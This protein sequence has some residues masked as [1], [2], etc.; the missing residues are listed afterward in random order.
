MNTFTKLRNDANKANY[1]G[2]PSISAM[3][4]AEIE[5]MDKAR[6]FYP[7]IPAVVDYKEST[8]ELTVE[9]VEGEHIEDYA[10]RTKDFS[11]L[12]KLKDIFALFRKQEVEL[13]HRYTDH[14]K[15][16]FICYHDYDS[17]NFIV[18]SKGNI[19]LVDWDTAG[20]Y[21]TSRLPDDNQEVKD[22]Y[23]VV[24]DCLMK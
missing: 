16:G 23:R 5:I 24:F 3:T 10:L 13:T 21:P 2:F 1:F 8:R 20:L 4:R 19:W 17:T 12:Q 14:Y 11:I 22:L 18:D 15:K 7:Y 9:K 6:E